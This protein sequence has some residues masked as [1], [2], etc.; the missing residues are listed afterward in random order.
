MVGNNRI[1]RNHGVAWVECAGCGREWPFP[2]GPPEN[3]ELR[4]D[5]LCHACLS[6]WR[7]AL[8]RGEVP[9]APGER[10]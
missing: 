10:A 2:Q 4:R 3:P 1:V 7:A 5:F 9:S 6:A 8:Q